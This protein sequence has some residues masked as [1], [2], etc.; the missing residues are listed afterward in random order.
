[1]FT[2]SMLVAALG[3]QASGM[4]VCGP[5]TT[6]SFSTSENAAATPIF[7]ETVAFEDGTC[8]AHAAAVKLVKFCGP[9]ELTLSRMTC[10][11]HD[12]KTHQY[13]HANTAYTTECETISTA[14]TNVDGH[15]G[16]WSVNCG[17]S[18]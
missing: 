18:R 1:M 6:I 5:Q 17:A 7:G 11:Q 16:S 8:N 14:G 2:R 3:F 12:Y 10:N 13:T 15:L 4:K 9:G